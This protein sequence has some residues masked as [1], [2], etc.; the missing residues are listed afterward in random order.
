VVAKNAEGGSDG[1]LSPYKRDNCDSMLYADRAASLKRD[2][3]RSI[4]M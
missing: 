4:L 3:L 2:L 1:A